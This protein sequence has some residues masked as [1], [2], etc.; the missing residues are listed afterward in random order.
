VVLVDLNMSLSATTWHFQSCICSERE[1]SV[2][3]K[4]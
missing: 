1:N 2:A 4:P 3:K